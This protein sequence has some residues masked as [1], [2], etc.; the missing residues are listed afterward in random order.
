MGILTEDCR[1][2]GAASKQQNPIIENPLFRGW[3][4]KAALLPRIFKVN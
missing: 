3:L 1:G 2:E 4:P